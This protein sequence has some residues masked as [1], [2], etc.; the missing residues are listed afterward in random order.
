MAFYIEDYENP[1]ISVRGT[2]WFLQSA[3]DFEVDV[4]NDRL[5]DGECAATKTDTQGS[6]AE[7]VEFDLQVRPSIRIRRL[8]NDR[9]EPTDEERRAAKLTHIHAQRRAYES[10]L[11]KFEGSP[12]LE[13]SWIIGWQPLSVEERLARD[14]VEE[15]EEDAVRENQKSY[16]RRL[17]K[18]LKQTKAKISGEPDGYIL[19]IDA[20]IFI[21]LSVGLILLA[22][23]VEDGQ[24]EQQWEWLD[25]ALRVINMPK[26][27]SI[28]PFYE[29]AKYPRISVLSTKMAES[30]IWSM[31]AHRGFAQGEYERSLMFYRRAVDS[32]EEINRNILGWVYEGEPPDDWLNDD[33]FEDVLEDESGAMG[34]QIRLSFDIF[35]LSRA[36]EAFDTL[37]DEDSRDTN[38]PQ[39]AEHCRFFA[40]NWYLLSIP[41]ESKHIPEQ[42]TVSESWAI[43]HG[44]VLNRMSNDDRIKELHRDRDYQIED[45]LRLYFFGE[46][47]DSLPTKARAALISADRE[48]EN[49]RG[50][51]QGVFEDL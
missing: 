27:E 16:F 22:K 42:E 18:I 48:Y 39:V 15:Y 14:G 35:R 2:L 47:W 11:D 9:A 1:H 24:S 28:M 40:K 36:V 12:T 10:I 43:A 23:Q 41:V 26:T 51:R 17:S 29:K 13:G 19:D 30:L 21:Q 6:Q 33:S 38:W 8:R 32:F 50:R 4:E 7:S 46:T 34:Y 20:A 37:I 31:L 25:D 49:A 44:I 5:M 3:S 45:R